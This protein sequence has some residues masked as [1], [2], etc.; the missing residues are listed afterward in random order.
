MVKSH[1]RSYFHFSEFRFAGITPNRNGSH[2]TY[3]LRT[4]DRMSFVDVFES[5]GSHDNLT[6]N[7]SED[8]SIKTGNASS[9]MLKCM[10]VSA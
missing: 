5:L 2:F 8:K 3:E 6:V 9:K 10:Y 4:F 7:Y 1:F